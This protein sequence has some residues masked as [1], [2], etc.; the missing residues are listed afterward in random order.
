MNNYIASDSQLIIRIFQKHNYYSIETRKSILDNFGQ[1]RDKKNREYPE[2]MF[3]RIW[4]FPKNIFDKFYQKE[5]SNKKITTDK[6]K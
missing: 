4:R 6:I 3:C 1:K 5:R 2:D